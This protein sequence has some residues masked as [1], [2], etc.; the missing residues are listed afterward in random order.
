MYT[1]HICRNVPRRRRHGLLTTLYILNIVVWTACFLFFFACILRVFS[2]HSLC[3]LCSRIY[4]GWWCCRFDVVVFQQRCWLLLLLFGLRLASIHKNKSTARIRIY[5]YILLR[6][7]CINMCKVLLLAEQIT[8]LPIQFFVYR[9]RQ[10]I[11]GW[12]IQNPLSMYSAALCIPL[13]YCCF[14]PS[15]IEITLITYTHRRCFR[16]CIPHLSFSHSLCSYARFTLSII[17]LFFM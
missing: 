11:I 14:L 8:L 10:S 9:C 16:Y 1:L 5:T 15:S 7:K 12:V 6:C 2:V 17:P 13:V 3:V 4:L